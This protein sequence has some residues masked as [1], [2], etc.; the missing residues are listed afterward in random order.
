MRERVNDLGGRLDIQSTPQGTL[1]MVS[2]PLPAEQS[3]AAA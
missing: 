2:V 3:G 1:V